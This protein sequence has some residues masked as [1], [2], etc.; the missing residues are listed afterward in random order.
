[1][2]DTDPTF[3]PEERPAP[4]AVH[5]DAETDLARQPAHARTGEQ[6]GTGAGMP[7]GAG[8]PEGAGTGMGTG[9]G[10]AASGTGSG[11]GDSKA[12]TGPAGAPSG[13]G[14]A[15]LVGGAD[16]FAARWQSVQVT[17]VDEP[18][19]AVE[20]ADR[21][22]REVMDRMTELFSSQRADLE[23]TWHSGG[24]ASTE[25]LRVALQRYRSFFE[26][27]LAA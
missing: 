10:M 2:T 19:R 26:R 15:P 4:S 8:A 12:G 16:E 6:G 3:D 21:L 11:M 1:M 17:F 24:E 13:A 20:D 18:R 25:D 27:L 5:G 7:P 9:T 22:V 14:R 23:Q